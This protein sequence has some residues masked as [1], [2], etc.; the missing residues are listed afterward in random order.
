VQSERV[1]RWTDLTEDEQGRFLTE[2]VAEGADPRK[3]WEA[4]PISAQ[5]QFY[6]SCLD[7]RIGAAPDGVAL[8]AHPLAT[9]PAHRAQH[10][11]Y[12][13]SQSLC[14]QRKGRFVERKRDG[15]RVGWE[16]R[17]EGILVGSS[18]PTDLSDMLVIPSDG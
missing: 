15:K 16:R 18:L 5:W 4:A 10:V 1:V 9:D 2:S 13:A 6:A 17:G 12:S 7:A 8:I 3:V 14:V 11:R